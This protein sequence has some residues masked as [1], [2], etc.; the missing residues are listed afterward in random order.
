MARERDLKWSA[1]F[2]FRKELS[3]IVSIFQK[4]VMMKAQG[5]V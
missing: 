5:G 2:F 4:M 3:R 1:F